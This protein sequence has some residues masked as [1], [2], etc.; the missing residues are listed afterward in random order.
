LFLALHR[1]IQISFRIYLRRTDM[2]MAG[3]RRMPKL[4]LCP[5][6]DFPVTDLYACPSLFYAVKKLKL[7]APD[8]A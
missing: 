4:M 1:R 2:G 6:H 3:R 7:F 8:F 5:H